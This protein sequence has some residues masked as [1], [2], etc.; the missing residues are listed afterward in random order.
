[1]QTQ[2]QDFPP[3]PLWRRAVL[4]VLMVLLWISVSISIILGVAFFLVTGPL[5]LLVAMLWLTGV[6]V[7]DAVTSSLNKHFHIV[8]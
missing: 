6:W 2:D 3:L 1:M 8:P 7:Y 4:S 5:F